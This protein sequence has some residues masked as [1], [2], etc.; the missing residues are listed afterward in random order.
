MTSYAPDM[1]ETIAA[2][3]TVG[4][5]DSVGKFDTVKTFL[6]RF[7]YMERAPRASEAGADDLDD[8]TS[9]ALATYQARHGLPATGVFDEQTREMMSRVRCGFPDVIGNDVAFSTTCAWNRDALTYAFASGTGDV[10]GDTERDAVRRA[11][12][13]WAAATQFTFREVGTGDS[14][15]IRIAWT[16]AN[17]GDTDMTGGVLAHAD[18]PPGCGFYGN[19]LPRPLHF[20]DQENTWRDGAAAGEFDV[21][22]VALHE[23][24][25]ILGLSHSTVAGSVMWPTIAANSTVRVLAPDDIEGI[26]RLYPIRGPVFVRHSGLCLDIAGISTANGAE[27][28]QWEYW[29]GQN[30]VFRI[31]WVE[32]GHYRLIATHSGRVID[33]KGFATGNGA[34]IHQWDWWGGD[35]QKFRLD[36]VGHGYYRVVAKHSGR[37]LDV[38]GISANN[39]ARVVQWDWWGGQNQQW[40]LGPA[41]IVARHSGKA[42]DVNGGSV[43]NGAKIIQWPYWGGGNQR[44][45]LDPV[46]DGFYRIV[47]ESS[48]KCLDV[49][50]IST[51]NGAQIVQWEYWGGDNQKFKPEPT[52]AG[53]Y[54]LRA[55]HSGKVLDVSGGSTANGAQIIQ[56]DWWGGQN[57]QW[58]L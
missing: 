29:G 51:A 15:D 10:A 13:T 2:L 28:T 46:G 16:P 8:V 53:Y 56:W 31:E 27:A 52:G 25:H 9:L 22:T 21:E 18:Y 36:P 3:P 42:L 40:R 47:V 49:A 23:I 48:G 34:Q 5:H 17:C 44:L 14:P 7:G 26:R 20:D 19:A 37:V 30:Q 38:S 35:N 4:V 39:G 33:V 43:A 58:R 55:K 50:G 41:P 45:R 54:R 11:F 12:A 1:R 57:Q 24:G 6:A 32:A